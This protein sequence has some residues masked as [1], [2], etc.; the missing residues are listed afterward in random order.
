M[1]REDLVGWFRGQI[2]IKSQTYGVAK[3]LSIHYFAQLS[4]LYDK[5]TTFSV[6][7]GVFRDVVDHE[8]VAKA[9]ARVQ[10]EGGMMRISKK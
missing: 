10:E 2:P 8:R 4:K 6:N 5:L 1:Q 9:T 7:P 3:F